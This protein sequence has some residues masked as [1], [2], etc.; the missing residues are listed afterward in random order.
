M[1]QTI[2]FG[3]DL[4]TTNSLIAKYQSGKVEIFKS[5]ASLKE[6]LPSVV[7]FRKE[8]IIVGDKAREM[9][10][11]DPSN[12]FSLFK[13]KMGTSESF[14]VKNINDNRTPMQLSAQV[15]KE[16]KNFVHTGETIDSVVIT[17]PASFDTIQSNATK[18]AG[19][20]AGFKEVVLLQEPIAASLAF[21]NKQ[22]I[23]VELNGQWLGV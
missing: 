12:V 23:D 18:K 21:A 8:R 13:R 5:P 10:E 14:F 7:A 6:T 4:G 9:V 16:L 11:K 3:I 19:Y 2:N 20:E 15:L 1:S 17:I 22:D